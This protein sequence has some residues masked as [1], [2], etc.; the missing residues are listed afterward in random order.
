MKKL[1][2]LLALTLGVSIF[3]PAVTYGFGGEDFLILEIANW[4]HADISKRGGLAA[5]FSAG[6]AESI[7][8]HA[9]YVDSYGYN[10]LWWAGDLPS[11]KRLKAA[12]SAKPEITKVH[13]D[14]LVTTRLN[15]PNLQLKPGI[16]DRIKLD[17]IQQV[18]IDKRLGPLGQIPQLNTARPPRNAVELQMRRY[19]SGTIDG[20]IYAAE[21]ND[22]AM[23]HHILGVSL[24]AL[25][26]FYSHSNWIDEPAR[27][28]ATYFD[29]ATTQWTQM[30]S[31]TLY[32]GTYETPDQTG[33]KSHGKYAFTCTVMNQPGIKQILDVGCG[34][35]SPIASDEVCMQFKGCKEGKPLVGA[36]V[37][38][39]RIP[40]S[41]LY[42]A[43]VGINLD[44]TWMA[45]LG[46]KERGI[47][48][49][50]FTAQDAFRTAERNAIRASEQWL[51]RV[52]AA[53]TT[54]GKGS[55]WQ[56]VTTE[57]TV[58]SYKVPSAAAIA[59]WE[60][61]SK[62]GYQF[63]SAGTYPP[64]ANDKVEEYFL[65]LRIKTSTE[66][67]SGT[68]ADI[69]AVVDGKPF[70]LDNMPVH[71]DGIGKRAI[72]Y[73]DFEAGDNDV[74]LVGPLDHQP[75]TLRLE[76]RAAT[77]GDVIVAAAEAFVTTIINGVKAVVD[78]IVS[79]F[80]T[81]AGSDPDFVAQ[82][83]QIWRNADLPQAVGAT[84]G[85]MV[86]LNGGDEGN[87]KLHGTIRKTATFP[88][89][90]GG[91]SEY[92]VR[93]TRLEC[94]KESKFDRL[95]DSDEPFLAVL[96]NPLTGTTQKKLFGPFE[97]VDS[98]EDRTINY[99]FAPVRIPNQ[100]GMLT[101]PVLQMESD[102]ESGSER[103][104]ILN[105]FAGGLD[106]EADPKKAGFLDT[107]GAAVAADWKVDQVEVW[108]F[109]KGDQVRSGRVGNF[110]NIGWI[111]GRMARDF[112]LNNALP[113]TGIRAQDLENMTGITT[114]SPA[115]ASNPRG[116][117]IT[118]GAL[119]IA[120]LVGMGIVRGRRRG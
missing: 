91:N 14:D 81:L 98:G 83:K 27:R 1:R 103:T 29:M 88:G 109:S 87:Y 113:D 92:V 65:R 53:M 30:A 32:T 59:Q 97:D 5:S 35:F 63:V 72:S 94:I 110:T 76:N 101:L 69:F 25:Q 44:S 105:K 50:G 51:R 3:S 106:K 8:W 79:F 31:F 38:G 68:D 100:N 118:L 23:A 104:D 55:F 120:S 9:D 66:T 16:V 4:H 6:A 99:D 108:G 7:C 117:L 41:V 21:N 77:A 54:L 85:F 49:P 19:L 119:G 34:A 57:N 58:G 39:I 13:F 45:E 102:D 43:P 75:R 93:I 86:T 52:G 22:V 37:A 62:L 116:F 64:K 47:V 42:V 80:K 2:P 71:G 112:S 115:V 10:P 48:A 96:L 90:R 107:L 61:F 73:N 89:A 12:L 18:P 33:I 36:S 70:L 28:T 20:L 24:H 95:S 56:R 78:G 111:E 11:L 40:N 26:D 82:N 17:G 15:G 46:A 67:L 84:S 74:Y 60:D 114:T